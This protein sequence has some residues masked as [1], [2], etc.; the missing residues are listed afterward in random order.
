MNKIIKK[1]N[2]ENGLI[3]KK[4]L[5]I[6][7]IMVIAFSAM[8]YIAFGVVNTK[9]VN[10]NLELDVNIAKRVKPNNY[11]DWAEYGVDLND[12]GIFTDDWK[13]FYNDGTYVYLI[14][15]DYLD[16]SKIPENAGMTTFNKYNTYW[17]ED[18]DYADKEGMTDVTIQTANQFMLAKYKNNEKYAEVTDINSKAT[19]VLLDT[20]IWKDFALGFPGSFAYGSP[21]VE[22]WVDSWNQKGY[23]TLKDGV[24]EETSLMETE[25]YGYRVGKLEGDLQEFL[26]ISADSNGY[27]DVL[28]FPHKST[29][30]STER[31][32]LASP[33]YRS[34]TEGKSIIQA[35]C[36]IGDTEILVSLEGETIKAKDLK[37]GMDIVYYDFDENVNKVG[38]VN[39]VYIHEQATNF[40]KYT[41]DDGTYLQATDYHPIY[42][43]EGWK[44]LTNRNGYPIPEIGDEVKTLNGYKTLTGI[45]EYGGSEDCYDF[46]IIVDDYTYDNYYANNT[47][48]QNSPYES[49]SYT[50]YI[51]YAMDCLVSCSYEGDVERARMNVNYVNAA[52]RPIVVLPTSAPGYRDDNE[53]W[54][55]KIEP[56]NLIVHYYVEGEPEGTKVVDDKASYNLEADSYYTTSELKPD[57]YDTDRYEYTGKTTGDDVKGTIV[58]GKT[59]E[60]TYWYRLKKHKITTSVDGTGGH[61]TGEDKDC[62]EVVPHLED[63]TED[64]III[65]EKGYYIKDIVINGTPLEF[66]P[67]EDGTYKIEKFQRMTEDINIVVS[68]EKIKESKPNQDTDSKEK[69][70]KKPDSD[71]QEKPDTKPDV[72][73]NS[74]I[75]QETLPQ[76]GQ[77]KQL[78][79]IGAIATILAVIF[80]KKYKSMII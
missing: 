35:E 10:N 24:T 57:E 17:E 16:N 80:F 28:Y 74:V 26:N 31:Y 65:P 46:S 49:D 13:I 77:G 38:K 39:Q 18:S 64:I 47:L 9:Q 8:R 25:G 41:F 72:G 48:V 78:L 1:F 30:D 4:I 69:P 76:T 66:T 11:G 67:N 20:N 51:N 40:V 2:K 60:V 3:L 54:H 59:T 12:N 27:N 36:V 58:S 21:T 37:E 33:T 71:S 62:F 75:P 61:I 63:N 70:D 50:S 29:V 15:A 22:M 14:A 32:F 5:I 68:F 56:G 55:L 52:I 44:S 7:I 34:Y 45:R 19:A 73:D 23:G 6:F 79:C 42:T 53:I 43:K